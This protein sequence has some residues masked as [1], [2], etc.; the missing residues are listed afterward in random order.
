[1]HKVA[2]ALAPTGPTLSQPGCVHLKG[3]SPLWVF[4]CTVSVL[5]WAKDRPQPP[6]K[7]HLYVL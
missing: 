6:L 5:A 3:R 7:V 4:K 2:A 1:M